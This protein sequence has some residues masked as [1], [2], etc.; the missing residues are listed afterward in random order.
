M[1]TERKPALFRYGAE[2]TNGAVLAPGNTASRP[3]AKDGITRV[4]NETGL[5]E[6]Y[7][8]GRWKGA[9]TDILPQKGT[10]VSNHTA[11]INFIHPV[12]STGASIT[13]AIPQ[14]T[15]GQKIVIYDLQKT[16][17]TNN[18]T[19]TPA[20]TDK[21]IRSS[22]SYT[23]DRKGDC[24]TLEWISSTWG[25]KV[26][27][28]VSPTAA[29]VDRLDGYINFTGNTTVEA[30]TVHSVDQNAYPAAIINLPAT[31]ADGDEV[32]IFGL[33]GEGSGKLITVGRNGRL[34]NRMGAHYYINWHTPYVKFVW[35]RN[36]WWV[37]EENSTVGHYRNG[38]DLDSAT[39]RTQMRAYLVNAEG[40]LPSGAV[41]NNLC[42][43]EVETATSVYGNI[44]RSE[45]VQRITNISTREEYIRWYTSST[46]SAWTRREHTLPYSIITASHNAGRNVALYANTNSSIT[47]NLYSEPGIG[48]VCEVSTKTTGFV[49]VRINPNGKPLHGVSN[50]RF[51]MRFAGQTCRFRYCGTAIGWAVIENTHENGGITYSGLN[52]NTDTR[53]RAPGRFKL[54]NATGTLPAGVTS[55]N[56]NL[57]VETH[58]PAS[59]SSTEPGPANTAYWFHVTNM[60]TGDKFR[61]LWNG[62]S[63]VASWKKFGNRNIALT[64]TS[65]ATL[66]IY[67]TADKTTIINKDTKA[68]T[69]NMQQTTHWKEGDEII[70]INEVA[71]NV[72]LNGMN[73]IDYART[74][75][76]NSNTI[77]GKGEIAFMVH[78]GALYVI[79]VR[80]Q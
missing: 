18:V 58:A 19:L 46:W 30:N 13:I 2:V 53:I 38:L 48:D 70:I 42:Y 1:S 34:I 65:A 3:T 11:T 49:D 16:F 78:G 35:R 77:T 76:G 69:F 8:G 4:N 64:N 68:F 51:Y 9:N 36:S 72:T 43:L 45:C 37:V 47:V 6:W 33:S 74:N 15:N 56:N 41:S 24:V 23:L 10:V 27:H 52:V 17:D 55:G 80:K 66:N 20:A 50:P 67:P 60:D 61:R 54:T 7:T 22:G 25:W 62:S 39:A 57:L 59:Y 40:T 31:S 44:S 29:F 21:I 79:G 28:S 63:W 71:G 26:T 75:V 32:V 5:L 73:V 14:G 12:N